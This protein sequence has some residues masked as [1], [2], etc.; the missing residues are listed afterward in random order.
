MNLLGIFH[1]HSDPS[2]AL[3]VDD[4]VVAFA[5]EERLS[6]IKHDHGAFPIRAIR[7]V[8]EYGSLELSDIDY[9][10]QAWDCAKY[11]DGRM[12]RRYEEINDRYTTIDEDRAY[13]RRLLNKMRSSTQK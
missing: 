12:A 3:L 5:E 6:R 13:Q 10:V 8:L 4:E 1:S 2:A 11:D 7:W 9:I